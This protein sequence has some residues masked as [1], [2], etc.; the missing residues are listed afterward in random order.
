VQ[1]AATPNVTNSI[2]FFQATTLG[3]AQNN[4]TLDRNTVIVYTADYTNPALSTDVIAQTIKPLLANASYNTYAKACPPGSSS[5]TDAG[6]SAWVSIGSQVT[7]VLTNAGFDNIASADTLPLQFTARTNTSVVDQTNVI[8]WLA[9]QL[10]SSEVGNC[11]LSKSVQPF[12]ASGATSLTI[13]SADCATLLPNRP[14][15]LTEHLVYDPT[16][17]AP[18]YVTSTF[19]TQA[20][21]PVAISP[22]TSITHCSATL[23]FQNAAAAPANP[24]DTTYSVNVGGSVSSGSATQTRVIG[25][26]G[27]YSDQN[28]VTYTNLQSGTSYSPTVTATNR[29]GASWRSSSAISYTGFTTD[30][31]GGTASIS[32]IGVNT[33]TY[34]ISG[35]TGGTS[36]TAYKLQ[37][38]LDNSTW[39]D[40][41]S[42]TAWA[43]GSSLSVALSGLTPNT[44]Y[45]FRIVLYE[46]SLCSS[47]LGNANFYTLPAAPTGGSLSASGPRTLSAGWTDAAPITG[48]PTGSQ[49]TVQTCT[50]G[51]GTGTCQTQ[52]STKNSTSMTASIT[53]GIVPETLYYVR[54]KTVSASGTSSNDSA[55]L[56]LGSVTTPN[57]A[58][59]V[60]APTCTVNNTTA[61]CSDAATD[62]GGT[63]LL[64]YHWSVSPSAGVTVNPNDQINNN[65]TTI[66]FPGNGSYTVTIAVTDHSGTG[67]TGTNSRS[68]SVGANPTSITISPTTTTVATGNTQS[69]TA[70]VRDQFNAIIAGASVNWSTSGGGSVSPA[71]GASTVFSA[72]APGDF[73]LTA[74]LGSATPGTAALHIIAAGAYFVTTPTISLNADGKTANVSALG[75]DN[76]S[77]EA[78][79]NYTWSLESGPAAISA[80]PNGTNAAKNAVVT[81]SRAGT[82]VL[83]CTLSNANGAVHANTPSATVVQVLSAITVSPNNI[84]IKTMQNQQ[85]SATGLDQFGDAMTPSN[86]QWST[87]G[88]SV[89]GAGVFNSPSL[90]NNITVRARSGNI[91]GQATVSVVS[92]DVGNAYAYPVP[93]KSTGAKKTITFTNLGSSAKIRVYTA[94]GRLVF[95]TDVQSGTLDWTVINNSG[96][97]LASGVYFYVIESPE[98]KKDGKLIIIQ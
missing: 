65:A 20:K 41:G 76:V 53:S 13:A 22:A 85:F 39:S 40:Y 97:K 48:N 28:S 94:T 87:T 74:S 58:P 30:S 56:N 69:F 44:R 32:N 95:N 4:G 9:T 38:S 89:S 54:V 21:D 36:L 25:G 52:T 27:V 82:Y 14:Y 75:A 2:Y 63:A 66:T 71:S 10:T 29:G 23:N 5:P 73:T 88:G 43:G 33:A 96:E 45:Y 24:S 3:S 50:T 16:Q 70:T 46:G 26:T 55:W 77:G 42:Q 19:Y 60:P 12:P 37:S 11:S 81:F 92:Y 17:A 98:T 15:T 80:S 57:E 47:T 34:T 61:S 7:D 64:S 91:V 1:N 59:T 49:Y 51:Y 93:Y 83:R 68:V 8:A 18:D 84:T 31:W 72:T 6:C 90:G 79:I 86:V 67:L 62:N 35:V 78:S